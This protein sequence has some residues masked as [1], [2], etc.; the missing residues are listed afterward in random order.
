[1]LFDIFK[2]KKKT[3]PRHV[4]FAL[5]L[6]NRAFFF[7]PFVFFWSFNFFLIILFNIRFFII[8]FNFIIQY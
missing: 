7:W 3:W 4:V 6:C 5:G 8:I 1:M 2:K